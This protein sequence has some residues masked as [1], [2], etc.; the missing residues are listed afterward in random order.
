MFCPRN[1]KGSMFGLISSLKSFFILKVAKN[2]L[3]LTIIKI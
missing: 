1:H 3:T 2:V